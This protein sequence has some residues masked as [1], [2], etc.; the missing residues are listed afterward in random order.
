[1]AE[2]LNLVRVTVSGAPGTGTLTLSTAV[3]GFLTMAQAG[4]IDGRLYEYAI[5]NDWQSGAW[6]S[7]EIVRGRWASGANTL[8]REQ[9]VASTNSNNPINVLA[10]AQVIILKDAEDDPLPAWMVAY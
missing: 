9:T 3:Q 10:G 4:A 2:S 6:Q 1:M 7:R 5:E 8:T